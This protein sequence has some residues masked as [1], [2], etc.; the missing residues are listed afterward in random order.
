MTAPARGLPKGLLAGLV[1]LIAGCATAYQHG[2]TA[3]HEGRYPEAAARFSE[4]LADDPASAKALL[5]LGLAQY[6]LEA[7]HAAVG[8]LGRAVLAVPTHAEARLYLALTYLALE[9]QGA[10]ARHLETLAGLGVH[11][12]TAAQASRAAALLH[13]GSLSIETREFVRKSL[14]NEADWSRDVIE[15]RLAPHMYL[16]PAW[17]VRDPAGLSPLGW[18]PYGLPAP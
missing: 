2:Q 6:H 5:G 8:S 4:A 13:R 10:A 16:G 11:A 3:L 18:Y 7:F 1:L 12:R 9:D 17:F 15:A 14:E